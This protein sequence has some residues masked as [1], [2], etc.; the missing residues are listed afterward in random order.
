[1]ENELLLETFAYGIG[2]GI[3]MFW[4]ISLLVSIFDLIYETALEKQWKRKSLIGKLSSREYSLLEEKI[5]ECKK[6]FNNK[7]RDEL[8]SLLCCFVWAKELE[9]K[10]RKKFFDK[11]KFWKKEK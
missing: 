3:S 5:N 4:G 8:G 10:Q 6:D 9:I 7:N 11:L 1:M 2:Y